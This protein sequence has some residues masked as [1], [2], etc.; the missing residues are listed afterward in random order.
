VAEWQT[1]WIQNCDPPDLTKPLKM[2]ENHGFS[3]VKRASVPLS[4]NPH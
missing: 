1:R 4:K 3:A 2:L